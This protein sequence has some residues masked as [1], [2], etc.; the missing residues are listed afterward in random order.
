M[1]PA[2]R[3]GRETVGIVG[4]RSGTTLALAMMRLI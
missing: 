3:S 1:T 4:E 2:Q